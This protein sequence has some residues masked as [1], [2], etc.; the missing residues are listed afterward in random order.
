MSHL[1]ATPTKQNMG[2]SCFEFV[3]ME[4]D[5]FLV[6]SKLRSITP[7]ATKMHVILLSFV[8]LTW[9]RDI[10]IYRTESLIYGFVMKVGN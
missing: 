6:H 1:L 5:C 3:R 10:Y 9:M 8:V 7:V 2:D 4:N